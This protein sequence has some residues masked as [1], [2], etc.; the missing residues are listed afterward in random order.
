[1]K[2]KEKLAN[3]YWD[4]MC[5]GTQGAITSAYLTGFEKAREMASAGLRVKARMLET[6]G[7]VASP[8]YFVILSEEFSNLGEEEWNDHRTH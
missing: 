7:L 8:Q 2:L 5:E 4:L 6:Q 1:M 3:E